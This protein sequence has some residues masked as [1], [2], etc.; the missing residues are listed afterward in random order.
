MDPAVTAILNR[1]VLD[2]S[3]R[4]VFFGQTATGPRPVRLLSTGALDPFWPAT[5]VRLQENGSTYYQPR[6]FRDDEGGAMIFYVGTP[7]GGNAIV[8]TRV[9]RYGSK[10][11]DLF[12]GSGMVLANSPASGNSATARPTDTEAPAM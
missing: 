7:Y 6:V 1:W 10:R 8:V 2:S 5:G 11:T 3:G 9:N 12:P 4:I